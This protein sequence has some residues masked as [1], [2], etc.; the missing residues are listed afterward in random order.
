MIKLS[1]IPT[2][3]P[4]HLEKDE[5]R[6]ATKT[7]TKQL[8]EL[9]ET[10]IAESKHSLLVVFQ[11]MD[12]SGKDG[13]TRNVFKRCSP[14]G[15]SVKSFK[16]PT[17]EEFAHDF[18][19]RVHKETPA[20]GMIKVFNRSHYEDILIQKVHGWISPTMVKKR[21]T[22]I[23]AF[24][25]LLVFDNN[26]TILKFY[27]HLSQKRQAEK[28]QERIDD[29]SKNWKHNPNDWEEAKLWRK[30]RN[31]YEFAIN[32][33]TIPWHVV[34]VDQRWYRDYVIARQVVETLK[35][36]KMKRPVLK[37]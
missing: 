31:A 6:K 36:L 28:L 26:T 17:E 1:K 13:A 35:K 30:Y 37:K 24:E 10:M 16:K 23:N 25:E 18:L 34:P 5:I 8:A 19:W 2:T 20:K 15:V 32:N 27:M 9:Q 33:S 11:G 7:L 12:S 21:M 14:S 22:A 3:A 4:D 29:P